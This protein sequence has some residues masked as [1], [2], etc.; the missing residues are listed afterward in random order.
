M[1]KQFFV[2]LTVV[3]ALTHAWSFSIWTKTGYRGKRR[4]YFDVQAGNTCISL[5]ADI[6]SAG[7]HSFKFCSMAYTRCSITMHSAKACGGSILGSAT[8]GGPTREW[9]KSSVSAA[10]SKMKS[11]KI[12]GCKRVPIVGNLDVSK[13]RGE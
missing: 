8:A 11:F 3:V 10:G 4:S 7:V 1:H 12:Q 9:L 13:C 2:L 6:T 5:P